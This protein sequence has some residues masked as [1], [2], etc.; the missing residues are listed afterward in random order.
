MDLREVGCEDGRWIELA[1]NHDFGIGG[2]EHSG[3]ATEELV[4]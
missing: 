1:Q 4:S 2:V 3:S